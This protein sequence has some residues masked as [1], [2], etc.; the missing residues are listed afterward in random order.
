MNNS[1]QI[2]YAEDDLD[3]QELF[4]EAV[5]EIGGKYDLHIRNDG[6]ELLSLIQSPPP[7][8]DVIF[9]DL[10]M[11]LMNGYQTLIEIRKDAKTRDIPVI[12]FSTSD[13][14]KTIH[15]S[16][17]LGANLYVPKPSSYKEIKKVLR[18]SLAIDW[19]SFHTTDQNFVF[20]PS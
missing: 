4:K 6:R 7:Q 15:R 16:R 2:F 12:I 5:E 20:R 8:P 14:M 17:E 19:S 1:K 11:P 13:D 9:L 18:H 10:N 3:D